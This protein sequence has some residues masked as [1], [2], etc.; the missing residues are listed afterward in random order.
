MQKVEQHYGDAFDG[1]LNAVKNFDYTLGWK[2][3]TYATRTVINTLIKVSNVHRDSSLDELS[4]NGF[5]VSSCKTDDI[6]DDGDERKDIISDI[7]ESDF[8]DSELN[9]SEMER[10]ILKFH[11]DTKS[12][13][14]NSMVGKIF[15]IS[16]ETVRLKKI[17][18]LKKVESYIARKLSKK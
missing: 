8:K 17:E 15:S 18:C 13:L 3:S 16:R 10:S 14:T 4:E 5:D 1:L 6:I 12:N 11:I 9:F 7:I 2:F